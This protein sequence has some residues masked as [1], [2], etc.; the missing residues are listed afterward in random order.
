M[1]PAFCHSANDRDLKV[2]IP[3]A[4]RFFPLFLFFSAFFIFIHCSFDMP[5]G[6]YS[7]VMPA[8]LLTPLEIWD[9]EK[10]ELVE[11]AVAEEARAKMPTVTA[12]VV[13]IFF[14]F[15]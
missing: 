13:F 4:P 1:P 5:E 14:E 7:M 15:Q 10:A 3:V 11:K 8:L 6:M 2:V 12:E 9:P